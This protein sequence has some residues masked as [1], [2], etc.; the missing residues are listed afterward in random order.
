MYTLY[1]DI[2][3]VPT[4]GFAVAEE[5]YPRQFRY[6]HT[7]T[8]FEFMIT[9]PQIGSYYEIMRYPSRIILDI[10][11][12]DI[13]KLYDTILQAVREV[14]N[15]IFI[16]VIDMSILS[17]ILD[18]THF[19]IVVR[20]Y[21]NTMECLIASSDMALAIA[22]KIPGTNLDTYQKNSLLLMPMSMPFG[23]VNFF[24]IRNEHSIY[25][26]IAHTDGTCVVIYMPEPE[27]SWADMIEQ[28]VDGLYITEIKNNKENNVNK[29]IGINNRNEKNN[30]NNEINVKK[31]NKKK[32]KWRH[33]KSKK[34][35][36][37][38]GNITQNI[39]S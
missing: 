7:N 21:N 9:F 26:S 38:A 17:T 29:E 1:D 12:D 3:D 20:I 28:N 5:I 10:E 34:K 14:L 2:N 33:N 22:Q 19:R 6:I 4:N 31:T 35:L 37:G 15:G 32:Q 25:N 24:H 8:V 16:C 13:S 27:L 18:P 36:L 30:V 23:T 11:T 39:L